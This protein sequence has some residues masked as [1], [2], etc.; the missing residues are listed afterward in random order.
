MKPSYLVLLA[1]TI[2][3]LS[4]CQAAAAP[5][6]GTP[7]QP[8]L[9]SIATFTVTPTETP[10]PAPTETPILPTETPTATPIPP[11]VGPSDFPKGVNPLTGLAVS[12]PENLER[13]PVAVKI[14]MFPRA[15]RPPWGISSADIVFDFVQ[16]GGLTR[17]NALLY[18][19]D[20]EQVGPIRSARLFD[21]NIL[22]GY[23]TI[24]TFGGAFKTVIDSLYSSPQWEYLVM[25]GSQNCPPMCRIEPEANNYLVADTV[26][27]HE[28]IQGKGLEDDRQNLDGMTFDTITP[29]GGEPGTE[30]SI[31]YSISAY[32]R[33]DYDPDTGRYLRFQDTQEDEGT[34]EVLE[35]LIDRLNGQQVTADNVVV[36]FLGHN[37][38]PPY[39]P[40]VM[41]IGMFGEGDAIAFRDGQ[42]YKVRWMRPQ[43]D[44]VVYLEFPDGTT[45]PYKPG[46]TWY[47]VVG[48]SSQVTQGEEG[49][50]RIVSKTP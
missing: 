43:A 20:V 13:R 25:E 49:N 11:A 2:L 45:Y 38:D 16:N 33:W 34:G 35:P 21:R 47:Q 3:A 46:I 31:R 12:D 44:S 10:T 27:L 41:Q 22:E 30:L 50:W 19:N 37:I 9:P 18:G 6:M 24:L 17:F 15:G 42:A 23:K 8:P 14:Q 29:E 40:N 7:T 39:G 32:N 26:G 5:P 4:A 36:L 48:T 28:Y 1:L